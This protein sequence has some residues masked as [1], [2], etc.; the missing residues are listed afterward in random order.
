MNSTRIRFVSKIWKIVSEWFIQN[1]TVKNVS[2]SVSHP[3]STSPHRMRSKDTTALSGKSHV[4]IDVWLTKVML[5]LLPLSDFTP[6]GYRQAQCRLLR[7]GSRHQPRSTT[8]DRKLGWT[9]VALWVKLAPLGLYLQKD[10]NKSSEM[11]LSEK[12]SS[13]RTLLIQGR[14]ERTETDLMHFKWKVTWTHGNQPN[15]C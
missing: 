2:C 7:S 13:I 6:L 15:T 12:V 14:L 8:R 9:Y 3:G 1:L 5:S 4:L 11:L 10:N